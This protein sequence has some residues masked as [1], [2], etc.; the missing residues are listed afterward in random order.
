M[1]VWRDSDRDSKHDMDDS[2]K[3]TG[4]FGINLHK[5]G[6]SSTQVDKWSAGCQVFKNDSDFKSFMQTAKEA[7]KRLGNSF[8]YT[9]IESTDV[10][11]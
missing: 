6:R 9:L 2:T 7:A 1:T 10:E 5:A 11:E 4:W 8:T 3:E